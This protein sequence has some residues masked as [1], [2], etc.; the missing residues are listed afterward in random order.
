[1]NTRSIIYPNNKRIELDGG[2]NT[3]FERSI[4]L[5][6]ESPD[7]ANV[8]FTNGAVG[9]REGTTKLTTSG[10]GSYVFDGLYTRKDNTGAET[11]VAWAYGTA[12]TYSTN[13]FTTIPSAQS[14]FTALE[15]VCAAQYQG[16]IF[17]GNGYATPYKYNG[18][19]FTRHGVYTAVCNM[20][21]ATDG[22]GNLASAASAYYSW[23]ITYINS[24]LVEGSPGPVSNTL[25]VATL[26]KVTLVCL[27]I[28]PQS[29]GVS[30]RKLYR[31]A[32]DGSEYKLVGT[33]S[34]NT[35]T[36]YAD[37]IAD[38]SLGAT[39]PADNGVPP[40]YSICIY[41]RDRLF[42][43]DPSNPNY[44]WYS[45]L[46]NPY[47]FTSASFFKVGDNTTDIVTAFGVVQNTLVIF[48]QESMSFLYM[49]DTTDTNWSLIAGEPRF[50]TKSP[51]CIVN[52]DG[53]ILFPAVKNDKFLGFAVL[54]GSGIEPS[55][56]F[57][58]LMNAG[59]EFISD[60]I[61]PDMFEIQESYLKHISGIVYKN[62]VL[63]TVTAGNNEEYNNKIWVY[64]LSLSNTTRKQAF[65]WVPWTGLY[66]KQ[67]TV[68]DGDLI[69]ADSTPNRGHIYQ[70]ED[71]TYNDNGTA[72]NSYL[73]TK[74]LGGRGEDL[75]FHK[76]FR[77]VY[78]L[79]D[80]P[81]DY[82][83]NVN[84]RAD[85]DSSSGDEF[86]VNLAP[87]GMLWGDDWGGDW[88]GGRSQD[89]KTV[90]VNQMGKRIQLKFSNQNVV[91]QRFKVHA[92]GM[93]YNRK[94]LR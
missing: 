78:I 62:K 11:M 54:S 12:R 58:T 13:T 47:V 29:W 17:F 83:M 71:G 75:H 66:P 76:D 19:D 88:G 42:V 60:R 53:K 24:A 16:H 55:V 61:Q 44:F 68:M 46:G 25:F 1:M 36:T 69:Y 87:G 82:E 90:Q 86:E 20:T 51:R 14:V 3:K 5:E 6:N 56:T 37:N 33:I 63:I 70:L 48:G 91:D 22:A 79:V 65:T 84:A 52:F 4:I 38:G 43:N 77:D 67:F 94:G 8:V 80:L 15:N 72:I 39:A 27:P 23:K 34:D 41:Y 64:D 74:E 7:C 92:F 57:L 89:Q 28:A 30:T 32:A 73:W 81:G 26:N 2:L 50:G 40:L 21:A 31:T 9:T 59:S 49:P 85:S 45:E 10:I 93:K 35:T 18:T